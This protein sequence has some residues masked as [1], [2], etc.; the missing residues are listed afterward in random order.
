L[1]YTYQVAPIPQGTTGVGLEYNNLGMQ[2]AG[3]WV[4]NSYVANDF[5]DVM[6]QYVPQFKKGVNVPVWGGTGAFTLGNTKFF[7]EATS[8]SLYLA[9][10][11]FVEEWMA[12]GAIPVLNTVAKKLVPALGVPQNS[13]LFIES[14]P[15][16]KAVQAPPQYA[17]IAQLVEQ[18][19]TDIL[20]NKMDIMTTLRAAD[21]ELNLI[22]SEN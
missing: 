16:A 22:L 20:I 7:D 9:S 13:E 8:L 21:T 2:F 10:P 4:T 11:V 15:L 18:A 6:V 3:R 17:E 19:M 14:A 12:Y 5:K 1:I